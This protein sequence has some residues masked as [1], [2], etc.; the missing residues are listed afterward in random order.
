[1]TI[2][3]ALQL[4]RQVAERYQGTFQDH[5]ALQVALATIEKATTGTE[6]GSP[7]QR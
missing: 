6:G 5:Q 2:E 3:Q 4:L 1:M 7:E